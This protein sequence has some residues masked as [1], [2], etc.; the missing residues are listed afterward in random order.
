MNDEIPTSFYK[1]YDVKGAIATLCNET[2]RWTKPLAFNDPFDN[3]FDA[4]IQKSVGIYINNHKKKLMNNPKIRNKYNHQQK[5]LINEITRQI[6][7]SIPVSKN[8][9]FANHDKEIKEFFIEQQIKIH[10]GVFNK[11]NFIRS[12]R[13]FQINSNEHSNILIHSSSTPEALNEQANM[14]K[15]FRKKINNTTHIFCIS[16]IKDSILMWSHY[17]QNHQGA[18]IEFKNENELKMHKEVKYLK[19]AYKIKHYFD[20][21]DDEEYF[22]NYNNQLIY[23]KA[24]CWEYEK[25]WRGIYIKKNNPNDYVDLPFDRNEVVG[26][27]LGCRMKDSAKRA[28]KIIAKEKYPWA[29]IYQARTHETNYSLVFDEVVA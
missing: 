21:K 10:D 13:K 9:F 23:T 18:V 4:E 28:I 14:L 1:Y 11:R 16:K 8:P 2:R 12:L 17:A 20:C 3:Q 27:Y 19:E 22:R 7:S 25:E 5:T 26:I 24:K 6:T 15:D 29:K